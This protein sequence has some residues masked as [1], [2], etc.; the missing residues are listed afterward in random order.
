MTSY[1]LDIQI[2]AAVP[3]IEQVWVP[4]DKRRIGL[5]ATFFRSKILAAA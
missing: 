2:M 5:K 1:E 3:S 4:A